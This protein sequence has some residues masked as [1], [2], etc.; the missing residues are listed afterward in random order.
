MSQMTREQRAKYI[1][2]I[3]TTANK[4]ILLWDCLFEYPWL[5]DVE[6]KELS[7]TSIFSYNEIRGA[8]LTEEYHNNLTRHK[9]KDKTNDDFE[10]LRNF[11]GVSVVKRWCFHFE[12]SM[13]FVIY[14]NSWAYPV[15][16][17]FVFPFFSFWVGFGKLREEYL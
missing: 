13:G 16:L 7:R 5:T 8:F 4:D 14:W 15:E 3:A 1:I 17:T 11:K 9:M 10:H 12:K 6:C 2:S